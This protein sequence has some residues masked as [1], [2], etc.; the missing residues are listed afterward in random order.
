MFF[1][2]V[3]NGT[4]GIEILADI[5]GACFD[6]PWTISQWRSE[7]ENQDNHVYLIASDEE[8]LYPVGF[9]TYGKAGDDLELKKIAVLAAHRRSNI[10]SLAIKKMLSDARLMDIHNVLVEVAVT[11]LAAIRLYE[12][13]AFYKIHVRKKYY[14][15]LV[16]AIVMQKEV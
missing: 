9:M 12:K 16:D 8:L 11:N 6:T 13:H 3:E 5:D 7:V 10:A 4:S 15:N 14:N 2:R 1:T